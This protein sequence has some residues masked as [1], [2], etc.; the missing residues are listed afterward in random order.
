MTNSQNPVPQSSRPAWLT[1][2]LVTMVVLIALALIFVFT[3]LGTVRIQVLIW[4]VNSPLWALILVVL[5]VGIVIGS[6][7]PWLKGRKKD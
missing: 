2:R 4:S 6:L 3:N 1:T 5:V 7:F